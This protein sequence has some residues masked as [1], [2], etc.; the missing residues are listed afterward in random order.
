MKNPISVFRLAAFAEAASFIVL[1]T[2]AMPLKYFWGM[3][4]AVRIIGSLH[5]GLF[6]IYC[7]ALLQCVRVA[8]WP[9]G[10]TLQFFIASLIPFAPFFLDR[11]L[12]VYAEE[13]DRARL[14]A[15]AKAVAE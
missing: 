3:P 10:R 12:R 5:G 6:L 1:L 13:F 9:G 11:R 2:I 14:P 8:E 15:P 4:V 7:G